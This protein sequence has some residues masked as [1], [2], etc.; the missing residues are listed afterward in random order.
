M[1]E[2]ITLTDVYFGQTKCRAALYYIPLKGQGIHRSHQHRQPGRQ[3]GRSGH[4]LGQGSETATQVGV[5]QRSQVGR[6]HGFGQVT[7][8]IS[9]PGIFVRSNWQG[10]LRD[11]GGGR[12][13]GFGQRQDGDGQQVG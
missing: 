3:L 4:G 12:L 1:V 8:V 13:Q 9:G 2:E 5:A 11:L 7:Q 10:S 6:Q